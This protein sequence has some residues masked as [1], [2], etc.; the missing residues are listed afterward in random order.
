MNRIVRVS[1]GPGYTLHLLFDDGRSGE[2]DLSARLFGPVFGPVPQ[3]VLCA[4]GSRPPAKD[5]FGA[6]GFGR[7]AV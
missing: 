1:A 5:R 2:V 3:G 4:T 7:A 6:D